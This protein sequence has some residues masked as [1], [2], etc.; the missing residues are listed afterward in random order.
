MLLQDFF[1]AFF[2]G[3]VPAALWLWFWLQEDSANPEP[4]GLIVVTF[5]AGI[6]AIAFVLPLEQ[7]AYHY[8]SAHF[9]NNT[10]ILFFFLAL[11]EETLKFAAA[12][13]VALRSKAFDEPI[14]AVIYLV[15]AALGF[16]ALENALFLFDPLANGTVIDS[17]VTGNMRFIGASV[18]H[19]MGSAVVGLSL[20]FCFYK[21][22]KIRRRMIFIGILLATVL[23]TI[24]NL[25]IMSNSGNNLFVTFLVL[26]FSV[27]GLLLFFEKIKRLNPIKIL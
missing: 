9:K 7:I 21:D 8:I 26:W 23:H 17:I 24:F 27:V 11:I 1:Y 18:L 3:L 25:S 14:D 2:G 15:T 10:V 20:A 19:V 12:Y 16:A 22:K 5:I 13:M 6:I 4:R